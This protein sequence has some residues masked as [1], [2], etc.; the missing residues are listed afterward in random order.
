MEECSKNKLFPNF[1]E[2]EIENQY[3][4]CKIKINDNI[5]SE[6]DGKNIEEA[7]EKA[8]ENGLKKLTEKN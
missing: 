3:F 8:A 4:K 5:F 2:E 7:K 6:G 1:I